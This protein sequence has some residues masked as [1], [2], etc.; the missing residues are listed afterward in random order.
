MIKPIFS[1]IGGSYRATLLNVDFFIGIFKD[2]DC[3]FQLKSFRTAI[4]KNI[5][6]SRT[7]TV[8]ASVDCYH[9]NSYF[10]ITS[11]YLKDS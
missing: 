6:F 10:F 1:N 5:L 9:Q 2:F 7:P 4:F 11:T 8:A 3:K